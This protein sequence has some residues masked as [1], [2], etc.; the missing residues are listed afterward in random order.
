[1]LLN[2]P[3][4]IFQS[5]LNFKK[6]EIGEGKK[7]QKMFLW[8]SRSIYLQ[9]RCGSFQCWFLRQITEQLSH[10]QLIDTCPKENTQSQFLFLRIFGGVYVYGSVIFGGQLLKHDWVSGEMPMKEPKPAVTNDWN[11][12]ARLFSNLLGGSETSQRAAAYLRALASNQLPPGNL[13]PLEWH[14]EDS[15]VQIVLQARQEPHPVVLAALSPSI[16]LRAVWR[17]GRWSSRLPCLLPQA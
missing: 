2:K 10:W 5:S 6:D 12:L 8:W 3:W 9:Q 15:P 1:M 17:R 13:S 14:N 16:P 4:K 7:I 11:E